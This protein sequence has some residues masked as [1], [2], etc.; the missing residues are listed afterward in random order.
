MHEMST[1]N[2]M[3]LYDMPVG[4]ASMTTENYTEKFIGEI[5]NPEHH[6]LKDILKHMFNTSKIMSYLC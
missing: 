3:W 2:F 6:F 4:L 1:L 5:T